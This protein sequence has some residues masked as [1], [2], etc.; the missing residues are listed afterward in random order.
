MRKRY[1]P[2]LFLVMLL[3]V[4]LTTPHAVS[5]AGPVGLWVTYVSA[6]VADTCPCQ[7]GVGG[8]LLIVFRVVYFTCEAYLGQ[9]SHPAVGVT[10]A[11][12]L[13]ISLATHETKEY[14]NVPV[15][16]GAIDGEYRAEM[17]ITQD[18]PTGSV[19]VY[20]KGESLQATVDNQTR[21]GPPI[22]TSS[23]QTYDTS[24]N[25]I[26]V[27]G[28][29]ST[30]TTSTSLSTSSAS[31]SPTT[32]P[33]TSSSLP[34]QLLQPT[35]LVFLVLIALILVLMVFSIITMERRRSSSSP[36]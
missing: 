29:S 2:I 4:V 34:T 30:T 14:P 9:I 20:V 21:T 22:N 10:S 6:T 33:S 24:D 18:F 32:S 15:S 23:E 28:Q 8:R 3:S 7:P 36:R 26:V 13:L 17:L 25:S 12:F 35:V 16:P 5:Q 19:L 1:L 31:T 11:T 27:I